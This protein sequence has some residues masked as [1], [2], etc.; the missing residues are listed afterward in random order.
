MNLELFKEKTDKIASEESDKDFYEVKKKEVQDNTGIKN[1]ELVH[2][3]GEQF[4]I[5]RN[6]YSYIVWLE[7]FCT[8]YELKSSFK[9]LSLNFDED[10]N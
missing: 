2:D 8:I 4:A 7:G 5:F 10:S 1:W 3:G 9:Q 6:G